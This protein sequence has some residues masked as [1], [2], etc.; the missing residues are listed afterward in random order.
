[1]ENELKQ[2]MGTVYQGNAEIGAYPYEITEAEQSE[3]TGF[4]YVGD[5]AQVLSSLL[6][7]EL[8]L[9][10]EDG[11]Q[12]KFYIIDAASKMGIKVTKPLLH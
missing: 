3:R 6:G 1:M 7:E 11:T 9:Q 8:S 5:R 4:L 2:G 12:Y 10:L